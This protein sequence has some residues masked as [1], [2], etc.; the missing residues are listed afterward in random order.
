L[1]AN[2]SHDNGKT[3]GPNMEINASFDPCN[4][5]TTSAVYGAD[6]TLSLLYRE[7]TNN[8]RDMYLVLWEQDQGKVSRTR[9]SSTLWSI[10]ACPMSAFALSRSRDCFVAVWPTKDQI[11]FV[12]L[13]NKGNVLPPGEIKT[14]GMAGMHTGMFG[15]TADN[16]TTLVA[17]K[18]DDR[19]NWQLYNPDGHPNGQAHS[20][21]SPGNGVAGVVDNDGH[22]ILFE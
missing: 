11:Y 6:G 2:V 1:Y 15:L 5:C 8:D 19:L 17:W 21:R 22:F 9:I 13:D 20:V 12:R 14:D 3:F 7:E 18:K 16:G 10:T 4:C